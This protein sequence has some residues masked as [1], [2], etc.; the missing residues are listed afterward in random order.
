MQSIELVSVFMM[1]YLSFLNVICPG[2]ARGRGK[3][4]F[5]PSVATD[6]FE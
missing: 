1:F 6:F 3:K 4:M 5:C 2:T